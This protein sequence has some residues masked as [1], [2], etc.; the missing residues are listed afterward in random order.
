M[1]SRL[2]NVILE[3]PMMQ[4]KIIKRKNERV[5]LFFQD[6]LFVQICT[7]WRKRVPDVTKETDKEE[8]TWKQRK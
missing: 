2:V 7:E 1:S 4:T 8:K 3:L 5:C 6:C